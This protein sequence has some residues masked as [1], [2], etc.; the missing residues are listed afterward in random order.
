[1]LVIDRIYTDNPFFGTRRITE[2][3]RRVP[4][5]K[6]V[7]RKRVRRLMHLMGIEAIYPKPR[8]SA[9]NKEHKKYPYLLRGMSV[10][11]PNQVWCTDITYIPTKRGYVYLTAIMDWYSRYVLSWEISNSMESTFC[12][13]A[14]E[15]AVHNF[16]R[17]EILNSDQGVQFTDHRFT[18]LLERNNIKISMD[19]KGRCMDNIF[20]ERLWRSLKYEEV[21]LK[22]YE[23]LSDAWPNLTAYLKKYNEYRPHQ[24]LDYRTPKEVYFNK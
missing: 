8:L 14:L 9:G 16:G 3:I 15:R 19:G 22:E 2:C 7:S 11:R 17:P 4:E 1:M 5:W 6:G 18:G 20:I 13:K 24:S 12:L 10:E 23:T 21:Y